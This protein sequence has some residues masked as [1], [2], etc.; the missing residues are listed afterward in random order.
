[1]LAGHR[2]GLALTAERNEDDTAFYAARLLAFLLIL[3]GIWRKNR[4]AKPKS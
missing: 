4:A 3:L 2:L 1:M